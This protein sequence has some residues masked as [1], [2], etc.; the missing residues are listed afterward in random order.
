[1]CAAKVE[2]YYK[3]RAKERQGTRTDIM[4]NCPGSAT[5]RDEAGATFGVSGKNVDRA[6]HFWTLCPQVTH[7]QKPAK[8]HPSFQA[9]FLAP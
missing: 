8:I 5:A 3:A 9:R 6:S 4:D 1:M 7:P 2:D